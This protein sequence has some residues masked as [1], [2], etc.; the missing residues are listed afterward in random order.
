VGDGPLRK[1]I[2]ELATAYGIECSVVFHG[3]I[4]DPLKSFG[5]AD[6]LLLPSLIEGA[7]AIILE[8]FAAGIPVIAY[9]VGGIRH[10]VQ[11][12]ITGYL[13]EKNDEGSFVQAVVAALS[14]RNTG[15]VQNARQ[16]VVEH[17]NNEK[18]CTEFED[19]YKQLVV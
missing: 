18:I 13:V 4:R 5:H 19:L 14:E 15:L 2:E 17:Y 8:G 11:N 12:N 7:P 16:Q 9:N 6:A 10:L 3:A 1:N